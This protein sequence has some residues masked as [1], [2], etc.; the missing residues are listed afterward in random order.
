[1]PRLHIFKSI[2]FL[3]I[4]IFF[5]FRN[6]NSFLQNHL[7]DRE[8]LKY[9]DEDNKSN[10]TLGSN[11]PENKKIICSSPTGS[12]GTPELYDSWH[13]LSKI[14][15][16]I[17]SKQSISNNKEQGI[18]GEEQRRF[19]TIHEVDSDVHTSFEQ[20]NWNGSNN[21]EYNQ[22]IALTHH[23]H[24]DVASDKSC[25]EFKTLLEGE[26]PFDIHHAMRYFIFVFYLFYFYNKKNLAFY[27]LYKR[28]FD[29][30][31]STF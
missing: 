5:F 15:P 14:S 16:E 7:T 20:P 23:N 24:S 6:I 19:S 28:P 26:E 17:A 30:Y 13:I 29:H 1:M 12:P 3:L 18:V 2:F 9:V 25:E 21:S 4:L 27:E 22:S 10:S 8:N 11:I 31:V